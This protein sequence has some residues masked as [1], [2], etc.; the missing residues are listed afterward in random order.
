MIIDMLPLC[1]HVRSSLHASLW[2]LRPRRLVIQLFSWLWGGMGKG[3]YVVSRS[4]LRYSIFY[5]LQ[6]TTKLLHNFH[7]CYITIPTHF[8]HVLTNKGTC[9]V[10]FFSSWGQVMTPPSLIVVCLSILSTSLVGQ[11]LTRGESGQ[12][13]I[14]D[15]RQGFEWW[16]EA[17]DFLFWHFEGSHSQLPSVWVVE[18]PV[19]APVG[20][21][22]SPPSLHS[23]P[24]EVSDTLLKEDNVK[25]CIRTI[26]I[27]PGTP[28]KA[29]PSLASY[30]L[31][32]V[33]R[34]SSRPCSLTTQV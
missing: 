23:Q 29:R 19:E 34:T 2:L 14:T 24:P 18:L 16:I 32:S 6:D 25:C 1:K 17:R 10:I 20:T 22:P 27:Q 33:V 31:R 13:S 12:I 5:V 3:T 7:K 4:K 30:A 28:V 21:I 15:S 9:I 26:K 11:T 8:V